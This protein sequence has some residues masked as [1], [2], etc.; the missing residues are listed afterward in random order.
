M[1]SWLAEISH[2]FLHFHCV[3][4]QTLV[5]RTNIQH[6]R[7]QSRSFYWIYIKYNTGQSAML[8]KEGNTEQCQAEVTLDREEGGCIAP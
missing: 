7:I 3:D 1:T 2:Q 6:I 8:I 4:T 5:G